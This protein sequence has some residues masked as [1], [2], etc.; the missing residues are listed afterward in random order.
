MGAFRAAAVAKEKFKTLLK[1]RLL[2]WQDNKTVDL[3]QSVRRDRS[4]RTLSNFE[5]FRSIP[6]TIWRNHSQG[7]VL[8]IIIGK[9]DPVLLDSS[10]TIAY[11]SSSSDL[12]LTVVLLAW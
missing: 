2:V 1:K 5:G 12:A 11:V 7:N 9:G 4:I 10:P 8:G 6:A 3:I